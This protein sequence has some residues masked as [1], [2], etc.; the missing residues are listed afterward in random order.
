MAHWNGG[1][2][3]NGPY[4]VFRE[5]ILQ[6]SW[7]AAPNDLEPEKTRLPRLPVAMAFPIFLPA[8]SNPQTSKMPLDKKH[9]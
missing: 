1:V 9:R 6:V 5:P 8:L 2:I 7:A 4:E 3:P